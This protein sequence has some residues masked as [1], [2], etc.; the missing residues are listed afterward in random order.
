[1]DIEKV[2]TYLKK[3]DDDVEY[4]IVL[5]TLDN[6]INTG[7][8]IRLPYSNEKLAKFVDNKDG[9]KY[10]QEFMIS[11]ELLDEY[12]IKYTTTIQHPGEYIIKFP[13]SYSSTISFGFNLCEEVNL[14][15]NSWLN[16]SIEGEKWLAKQNIIP[17]FL[18]FKL[19][20]NLAVIYDSG[21]N[22]L[23]N[24]EIFAKAHTMYDQLY[25]EEIALRN[26]V[27]K[28]KIKEVII[29]EDSNSV[30]DDTLVN[31]YPSRI[32]VTDSKTKQSIILSLQDYL[33]YNKKT[34][35][36]EL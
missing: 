1:M 13:K 34:P 20:V 36:M 11:P 18:T 5:K 19:L 31:V 23:F 12:G 7:G 17:G 35:K 26:E 4:D 3:L 10:N 14:A 22:L 15:T 21:S 25:Q 24:S 8:D 33:E 6:L 28:L 30:S 29:D 16:Y 9:F 2:L 32:L 27:R